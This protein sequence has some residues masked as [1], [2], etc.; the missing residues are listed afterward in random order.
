MLPISNIDYRALDAARFRAILRRAK[1]SAPGPDGMPYSAWRYAGHLAHNLLARITLDAA[2]TAKLPQ[3][4][5][6]SVSVFLPKGE[7]IGP[8]HKR[9]MRQASCADQTSVPQGHR[10]ESNSDG[11]Q[12][13]VA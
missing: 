5:N 7:A 11:G 12:H 2:S 10:R 4:L 6:E 9:E 8:A 3:S 1:D 13:P